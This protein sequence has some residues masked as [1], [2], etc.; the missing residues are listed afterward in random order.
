MCIRDSNYPIENDA[1]TNGI[2]SVANVDDDEEMEI[3]I[4]TD[5]FDENGNGFIYAF[6]L[7]GSGIVAGFPIAVQGYTLLNG[8]A[9]G[10][11]DGDGQ[12]DLTALGYSLGFDNMP[13]NLFINCFN[14]ETP[15]SPEKIL[16]NTCL[17]YTSPSP[18]DA[19]L[20]RMP[21]SA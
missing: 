7:D 14:L 3:I 12:L 15:Y 10:D 13:L 1:G 16:W 21:S 20:S 19:T 18:R 17:L 6:N 4:P 8:A 11:I 9:L 2:I 5:V